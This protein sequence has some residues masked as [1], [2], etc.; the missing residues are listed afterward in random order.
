M[1]TTADEQQRS[2]RRTQEAGL[3]ET[4]V[5]DNFLTL[6]GTP[7]EQHR[8]Q[9]KCLWGDCY[10]V[11]VYVSDGTGAFRVAHSHF[12]EADGNGKIV[13]SNPPIK[14]VY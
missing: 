7:T 12:L 3:L 14:R 10:R 13:S 2:N 6:L 4:V 1:T 9:V 11:N 8:V 5:R